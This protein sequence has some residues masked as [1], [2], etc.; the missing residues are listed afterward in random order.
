MKKVEIW[1]DELYPFMAIYS[2][3]DSADVNAEVSEEFLADYQ[4]VMGEFKTIQKKLW[5]LYKEAN[6]EEEEE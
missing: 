1:C 2:D 6:P 5:E 4:R 3:D